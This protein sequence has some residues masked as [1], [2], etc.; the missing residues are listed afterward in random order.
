MD[1][2][3]QVGDVLEPGALE[4]GRDLHAARAV[5]A[6]ADHR[7]FRVQ[8][9][10]RAGTD[11]IGISCEPLMRQVSYSQGSRTSSSKGCSR[12]PSASQAASSGALR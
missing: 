8:L 4:E 7:L 11:C 10:L 9:L 2:A 3:G 1:A 6:D 12:V 5:V